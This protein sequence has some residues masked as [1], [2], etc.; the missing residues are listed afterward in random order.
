[1]LNVLKAH[2]KIMGTMF[3]KGVA[4]TFLLFV[5]LNYELNINLIRSVKAPKFKKILLWT[6]PLAGLA[7]PSPG[8]PLPLQVS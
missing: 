2:C 1:M 6:A 7:R 8:S 3:I 4:V 5:F